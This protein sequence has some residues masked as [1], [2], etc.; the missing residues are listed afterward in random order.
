M[1]LQP[2]SEFG[3]MTQVPMSVLSACKNLGLVE[4]EKI[5]SVAKIRSAN[6]ETLAVIT[7]FLVTLA[8]NAVDFELCEAAYTAAAAAHEATAD[9]GAVMGDEESMHASVLTGSK[10]SSSVAAPSRAAAAPAEGAASGTKLAIASDTSHEQ[11]KLQYE[12]LLPRLGITSVSALRE[13]RA[14]FSQLRECKAGVAAD[15]PE[16]ATMLTRLG[17]E[18]K[19]K[20]DTIRMRENQLSSQ[21]NNE[22]SGMG[23]ALKEHKGKL[24]ALEAEYASLSQEL[25]KM[26]DDLADET[27]RLAR[28]KAAIDAK[29]TA[30]TDTTPLGALQDTIAALRSEIEQM[31]IRI[32]IV[33]QMLVQGQVSQQAHKQRAEA[34][35]RLNSAMKTRASVGLTLNKRKDVQL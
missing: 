32:G 6:P 7:D 9:L 14:H 35:L 12:A 26:T 11:W 29:N 4:D 15:L 30:M 19:Q 33:N 28:I 17:K 3:D 13:W 23:R 1:G 21:L 25:A 22:S 8:L 5:L 27:S 20:V 31:E 18:T 34:A 10:A 16:T 2:I 24:L